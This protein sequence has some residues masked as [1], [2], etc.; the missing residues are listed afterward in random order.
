MEYNNVII[1]RY[2]E[3]HLKGNN[4]SF[5]ENALLFNLRA[6]V[7]TYGA[8][9]EKT[10][11]RYLVKG[12]SSID[13]SDVAEAVRCVFGVY[14]L[15]VGREIKTYPENAD[16]SDTKVVLDRFAEALKEFCPTGK[17]SFKVNCN[18]A[19]KRFPLKSPEIAAELGG[20]MFT[21]NDKLTV[22]LYNPDVTLSIDIRET[23][24][25][26]VYSDVVLG[27]KGMP[28]GTG[29]KGLVLLS[30]GIDSPVAVY[31]MAK[32]GMMLRAVHF[33]SYPY[34]SQRAKEKV[35]ELA[36]IVNKYA[37]HL[38]VDVVSVTEIQNQIHEKCPEDMM[39]TILRRFMMR[40]ANRLAA[41][42]GYQAI[43][44]GESL[45]QVASQTIESMTVTNAV[46]EYPVLRPLV[47]FDKDEII[48]IARKIGT[49][50]TS[51]QPF[52]DCCTVFLPKNPVTKPKLSKVEFF[53]RV[54]D[55]DKLVEDAL[56]TIETYTM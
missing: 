9:V 11:G 40:I 28:V 43:V 25:T 48:E 52:E 45:G 23:G 34:T 17:A 35:L 20:R 47:A 38:E 42:H 22:D 26:L 55:V 14:S 56:T 27:V 2:S 31:M 10:S 13:E 16:S 36:K 39:I 15:S 33:H 4:R 37:L 3:I 53:E 18:R 21:F 51:I 24:N 30:G 5:F 49:F 19:D 46:A 32:R 54:L 1:V 7:K 41:K 12:Y 6:A 29:G 44:T 8:H 50:A